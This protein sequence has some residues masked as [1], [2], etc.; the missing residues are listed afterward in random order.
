M[1]EALQKCD[2]IEFNWDKNKRGWHKRQEQKN[3][4]YNTGTY[5]KE[6]KIADLGYALRHGE[7]S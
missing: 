6:T 7:K 3:E 2:V 1:F 5:S 4:H